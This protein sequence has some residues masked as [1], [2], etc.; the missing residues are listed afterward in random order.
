MRLHLLGL[1]IGFVVLS[2]GGAGGSVAPRSIDGTWIANSDGLGS[3][4]TIML[5]SRAS[6]VSGSGT[7]STGALRTGVL[8]VAGTYQ[9]PQAAL[10]LSYDHGET[11]QFEATL[12]D[13]EHMKGKLTYQNGS[14]VAIEFVRP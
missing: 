1:G 2:C 10:T 14:V 8:T 7:Y 13:N 5:S 12:T 9:P 3:T 6:T 4:V 11:R